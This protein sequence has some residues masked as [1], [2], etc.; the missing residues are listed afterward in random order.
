MP[1]R[2]VLSLFQTDGRRDYHRSFALKLDSVSRIGRAGKELF[3]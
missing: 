2:L 3:F 1:Y